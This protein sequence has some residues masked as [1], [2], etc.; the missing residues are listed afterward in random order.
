M[1]L[2]IPNQ[3]KVH[4]ALTLV[5]FIYGLNYTIA[6]DVMVQEYL[7]PFA[8]IFLR[9]FAGAVIFTIYHRLFIRERIDRKD[10]LYT[11]GCCLFGVV[12][13][14]LCFFEG[15]KYTSPIHASLIM[16]LTPSLILV[17]SAV[18]IREKVTAKKVIGLLLGLLGAGLLVTQ[19]SSIS[20][21][22]ASV[23]GD[24]LVM[25]NA[26]SYG[27][28]LVLVRKLYKKYHPVTILRWIFTFGLFLVFPFGGMDAITADFSS[29]PISIWFSILYVL[30]MATSVVYLL[31]A[32]ALSIALPSMVGFYVY[33]QPLI[34]TAIS[35]LLGNDA[36]NTI[37]ILSACLLFTGVYF[38]NSS[39]RLERKTK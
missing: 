4:I 26:F 13:N 22:V 17:I 28:Y 36:L 18:V 24:V 23:Y 31:N 11:L 21:K 14:M 30:V 29:F 38:V 35:I 2:S 5:A 7:T 37:K 9:I 6:K 8:F 3:A 25:A 10:V 16:V 19:S 27:L 1:S 15:L 12:I 39:P 32:Y 34:A 33:F 20:E